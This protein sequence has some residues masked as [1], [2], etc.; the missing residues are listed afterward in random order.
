MNVRSFSIR[1]GLILTAFV[2]AACAE[3]KPQIVVPVVGQQMGDIQQSRANR[4][5]AIREEFPNISQSAIDAFESIPRALFVAD[6]ARH[7]AYEDQM[8]PIGSQQVTLKLSDI[9][10]LITNLQIAPT[11]IV[12]EVGTGTGYMTALLARISKFVYTSEI[13]EYLAE[14]ARQSLER[15][16]IENFKL[17]QGKDGLKGWPLRAPFDV[18]ILTA[19]V[20]EFP[21]DIISQLNPGARIA[22]PLADSETRMHWRLYKLDEQ[23]ELTEYAKRITNIPRAIVAEESAEF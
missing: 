1:F 8:L 7:R 4:I 20:T 23:G 15:L 22:V 18:V 13:N 10:W 14:N 12:Y 17:R 3:E 16:K 9:A 21:Q 5:Q 2:A 19:S 11:D 6:L